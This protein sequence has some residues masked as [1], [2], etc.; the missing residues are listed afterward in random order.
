MTEYESSAI[1]VKYEPRKM[2]KYI[3]DIY[4]LRDNYLIGRVVTSVKTRNKGKY[5][6]F[7]IEQL[8]NPRTAE[9]LS[10]YL[11]DALT[12]SVKALGIKEDLEKYENQTV[13]FQFEIQSENITPYKLVAGEVLSVKKDSVKPID[14][15]SDILSFINIEIDDLETSG[16]LQKKSNNSFNVFLISELY[17][18]LIREN[19]NKIKEEQ[20]KRKTEILQMKKELRIDREHIEDSK[21]RLQKTKLEVKLLTDELKNLGFNFSAVDE[22]NLT[23]CNILEKEI[24]SIP[25]S[26][27]ELLKQLQN[28]MYSR[29]K[30]LVYEKR[31]LRQFYSALKTNELVIL[32]GPSGTG[33][34][35]LVSVFAETIGAKKRI[36]PVQPSW[37]DKQD[38]LGFYNPLTK[39]YVSSP[40]LDVIIEAKEN[41]EKYNDK[42][43]LFLVCLDELNLA[44]VEYYLADILSV[45][46]LEDE[47]IYLYSK[48]EYDQA[49]EEIRWYVQNSLKVGFEEWKNQKGIDSI[50]EME[51]QQR[52]KNLTRFKP[53]LYIPDNIRFIGT[54]NVDGTTKPLSPKVIDRSFIIPLERQTKEEQEVQKIGVLPI[55]A[56]FFKV[57]VNSQ[58]LHKQIEDGINKLSNIL[59]NLNSNYNN[60]VKEHIIKYTKACYNLEKNPQIMLDEVILMK[61]LPRINYLLDN[62]DDQID[63]G[64]NFRSKILEILTKESASYKMVDS[65][66]KKSKETN[67]LSYWS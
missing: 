58:D 6:N 27:S 17:S 26:E 1:L 7:G 9:S 41:K 48:Y 28:Q 51:Y 40:L 43:D 38:L 22:D 18:K 16:I 59:D 33:K 66:V 37:T 65:M 44:Q 54:I 64:E 36:I 50:K 60:R 15:L 57:E 25:D 53:I 29:K 32:S 12:T 4:G 20:D 35:S 47:G 34:S 2:E 42:A 10:H 52:Y 46:E 45:R 30:R 24:L 63:E 31:I 49:I 21:A 67:V 39:Q 14:D 19:L 61:I 11:T 56:D 3:K 23:D 5:Q 13:I 62:Y 55:T 8:I